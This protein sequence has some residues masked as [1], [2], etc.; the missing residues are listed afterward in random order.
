[1][2][3]PNSQNPKVVVKQAEKFADEISE[4]DLKLKNEIENLVSNININPKHSLTTLKTL[5]KT[6]TSSMTS[7]PKPVKFLRPFY[8]NLLEIY[9][10]CKEQV[11]SNSN[12]EIIGRYH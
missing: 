9:N 10:N 12:T 7:V 6:S 5:I 1:M 2:S 3:I 8:Q 11:L 4:E